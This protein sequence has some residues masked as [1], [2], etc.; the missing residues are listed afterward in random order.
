MTFIPG[1]YRERFLLPSDMVYLDGNSLGPLSHSAR[2]AVADLASRQWGESLISSWNEHGWMEA[3]RRIGAKIAPLI[4]AQ[5][6]EVVVCDST[7]VNIFKLAA[8]ALLARPGRTTVLSEPGNF[9]TDLYMIEGLKRLRPDLDLK[10]V[11]RDEIAAALDEDTA[12][13][14]LT[15][16]HYKTGEMFDMGVLTAATHK[17]GALTLWDL[18]HSVGAVPVSLNRTQADLAVGC[19]YKYL[20]GGPGAPAFLYVANR[21]QQGLT[22]P[23]SGWLGHESPFAFDDAYRPAEDIGRWRAGTPPMLSL[24]A[25]EAGVGQFEGVDMQDLWDASQKLSQRFVERVTGQCAEVELISPSAPDAR[26]C[27]VSFRFHSAYEVVQALIAEGIVGD[28][29]APDAMRFGF[30]PLYLSLEEVERAADRLVDILAT[31]R[32]RQPEFAVRKGVT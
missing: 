25:L 5:A 21:H 14:L 32:W 20:N 4:G 13:L 12:L 2:D 9:P 15:H 27:H 22:S 16:V 19:G 11:P 28:F 18:S 24:A 17:A 30:T 6:D 26:G 10:L 29:R 7:S 31:G 1:A 8:A 3:P 23:L